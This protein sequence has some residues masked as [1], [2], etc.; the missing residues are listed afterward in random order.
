MEIL[1]HGVKFIYGCSS[2]GSFAIHID[3]GVMH[4]TNL[5]VTKWCM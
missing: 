2:Q 5:N 1:V 3:L 4:L